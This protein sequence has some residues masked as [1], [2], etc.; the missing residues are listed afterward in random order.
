MLETSLNPISAKLEEGLYNRSEPMNCVDVSST[1]ETPPSLA[2]K[3]RFIR[4]IGEGSQ[5]KVFLAIRLSDNQKVAIKQL[6]IESVS[7]WKEYD[8]FHRE[9]EVLSS[10]DIDGVARFYEAIEC[11]D[12]NPPCSYLV[13]EYIEGESLG[14]MLKAGHRFSTDDVYDI[15]IQL[16]RIL[17][18]LQKRAEPVVHRDIKPSNIMLTPYEGGYL[19][20]LIDFGA[21]ANPQVQSGGST[22]AGTYGYMPPEQLM[23]RPQPASDIYS[24]AAVAVEL[25]SGKSPATMPVKDFRLIFEPE[26]ESQSPVLVATLRQML[27]PDV[28]NRL[29]D[30]EQLRK[31]FANYKNGV[32]KNADVRTKKDK[33][34]Q[35]QLLAVNSIGEPGNIDLWQKLP[36]T[37]L[38]DVPDIFDIDPDEIIQ[39]PLRKG[40]QTNPL[41]VTRFSAL[42]VIVFLVIFA[43]LAAGLSP[44]IALVTFAAYFMIAMHVVPSFNDLQSTEKK[45][46]PEDDDRW[47]VV[48]RRLLMDGRKTIATIVS[49]DYL[50]QEDD[51]CIYLRKMDSFGTDGDPKFR[52]QYKFNPPDDARETDLLHSCIVHEDPKPFCKYGDPLPILYLIQSDGDKEK[53]YSMPYP[54]PIDHTLAAEIVDVSSVT[55]HHRTHI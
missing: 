45:F 1:M 31:R 46:A 14:S 15:I 53:V 55:N 5:A 6:N 27:E 47:R 8:L 29:C 26:V 51:D 43:I 24:L 36:D 39:H 54:Y 10:L 30:I 41:V 42:T 18:R 38:R 9:V 21:V 12:D 44:L 2:E 49:I 19:V 34:Y 23:G 35:N 32:F 4:K 50:P 25:F 13:Q 11:L 48:R 7:S 22:V 40:G 17:Y 33:A 3:Y 16:L 20:S 37:I 28:K 52:I